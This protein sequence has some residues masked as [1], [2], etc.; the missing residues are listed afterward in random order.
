ME[1]NHIQFAT[2]GGGCFWCVEACF[3]R[4]KGVLETKVG[5]CGG[6]KQN[7]TYYEV[8]SGETGHAEV[9]QVKFDSSV[10]SYFTLLKA[11]FLA[12]DPT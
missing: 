6:E 7:P 2:F 10:T 5:Y 3:K 8:K 9:V 12:H 11:F 4:I 1:D